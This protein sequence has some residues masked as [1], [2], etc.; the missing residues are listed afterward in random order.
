MADDKTK[1]E[2]VVPQADKQAHTGDRRARGQRGRASPQNQQGRGGEE[3]GQL[4]VELV[5]VATAQNGQAV[6]TFVSHDEGGRCGNPRPAMIRS[7]L[8]PTT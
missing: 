2:D 5:A 3:E 6:P 1:S 8:T 7:R 4:G